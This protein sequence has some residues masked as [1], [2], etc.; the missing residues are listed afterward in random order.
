MTSPRAA[1]VTYNFCEE[2]VDVF[3][4]AG[5][6]RRKK[7]RGFGMDRIAGWAADRI[8]EDAGCE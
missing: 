6:I 4:G 3:P 2:L 8:L 7:E 1:K 5:F